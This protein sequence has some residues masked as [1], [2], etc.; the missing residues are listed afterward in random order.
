ME[1]STSFGQSQQSWDQRDE[2]FRQMEELRTEYSANRKQIDL[3]SARLNDNESVIHEMRRYIST[4]ENK[5]SELL[6]KNNELESLRSTLSAEIQKVR[7]ENIALREEV[8]NLKFSRVGK[9]TQSNLSMIE[10]S[11]EDTQYISETNLRQV[12]E[13]PAAANALVF[14]TS[15]DEINECAP[16]PVQEKPES[17]VCSVDVSSA[18]VG[19]AFVMGE[20]ANVSFRE[21]PSLGCGETEFYG[22]NEAAGEMSFCRPPLREP[23]RQLEFEEKETN[24]DRRDSISSQGMG[25]SSLLTSRQRQEEEQL[26]IRSRSRSSLAPPVEVNHVERGLRCFLVLPTYSADACPFMKVYNDRREVAIAN[27][28]RKFG[29]DRNFES[30]TV[31]FRTI[32]FAGIIQSGEQ[33]INPPS[34][35]KGKNELFILYGPKKSGKKKYVKQ[36]MVEYIEQIKELIRENQRPGVTYR[37][38]VVYQSVSLEL[39]EKTPRENRATGNL[40]VTEFVFPNEVRKSCFHLDEMRRIRS[41][42]LRSWTI[43]L[44]HSWHLRK[45]RSQQKPDDSSQDSTR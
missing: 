43:S 15:Y 5:A 10:K 23:N 36:I 11:Y 44:Y 38:N 16:T 42:H 28:E 25:N 26:H 27:P 7:D 34:F 41:N 17:S 24:E 31:T 13:S 29:I 6:L 20:A 3:L 18:E 39:S 14:D 4:Q 37:L 2:Y 19:T 40:Y 9:D 12:H 21:T 35:A 22:R 1:S 8:T 45:E 30:N 33:D 32:K